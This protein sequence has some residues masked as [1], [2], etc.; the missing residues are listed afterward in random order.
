MYGPVFSRRRMIKPGTLQLV[1]LHHY[2]FTLV[3][4]SFSFCQLILIKDAVRPKSRFVCCSLHKLCGQNRFYKKKFLQ[5]VYLLSFFLSIGYTKMNK[6][7]PMRRAAIFWFYLLSLIKLNIAFHL[8]MIQFLC[9]LDVRRLFDTK[10]QN[11][12]NKVKI[13][14]DKIE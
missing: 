2:C 5:L 11:Y 12:K 14:V 8:Y 10:I 6:N 1:F 4:I 7:F 9:P 13:L 3:Y